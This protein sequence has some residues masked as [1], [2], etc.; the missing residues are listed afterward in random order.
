MNAVHC[1]THNNGSYHKHT[2]LQ[3]GRIV[4]APQDCQW[5]ETAIA[6]LQHTQ[7][8]QLQHTTALTVLPVMLQFFSSEP[9]AQSGKWLA[10][11]RKWISTHLNRSVHTHWVAG[12]H[13]TGDINTN[14][15]NVK[16]ACFDRQSGAW[17]HIT[18][19]PTVP[20]PVLSHTPPPLTHTSTPTH[21]PP[22]PRLQ[23]ESCPIPPGHHN[24]QLQQIPSSLECASCVEKSRKALAPS[25]NTAL[26][27][28]SSLQYNSLSEPWTEDPHSFS[29]SSSAASC[30]SDPVI[31][32]GSLTTSS[33]THCSTSPSYIHCEQDLVSLLLHRC[34][35]GRHLLLMSHARY[36]E[37]QCSK[38]RSPVAYR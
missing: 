28:N 6:A 31:F 5:T 2:H 17:Q 12:W 29:Y 32:G 16:A 34:I 20:F 7:Q 33:S 22:P 38:V 15:R 27:A 36:I 9:S 37:V 24:A 14:T 35:T 18:C 10:L 4:W 30:S 3:T 25:M 23:K 19:H 8:C 21:I 26:A 11:Q 1:H 13:S